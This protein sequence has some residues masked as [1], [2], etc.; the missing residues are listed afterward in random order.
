MLIFRVE[1]HNTTSFSS[2]KEYELFASA[3]NLQF[4]LQTKAVTIVFSTM[5]SLMH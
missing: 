3:D 5:K 4:Q 1:P 2:L